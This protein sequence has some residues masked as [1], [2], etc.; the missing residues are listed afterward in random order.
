MQLFFKNSFIANGGNFLPG[1]KNK[2]GRSL[3]E[4]Q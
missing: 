1:Q 2:D 3:N 4:L